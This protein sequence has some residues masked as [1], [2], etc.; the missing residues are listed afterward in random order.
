MIITNEMRNIKFASI[1]GLIMTL[2]NEREL[3]EQKKEIERVRNNLIRVNFK[4]HKV[5]VW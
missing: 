4:N 1:F 2:T 5:V 3:R